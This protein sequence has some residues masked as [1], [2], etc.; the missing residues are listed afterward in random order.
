MG[1]EGHGQVEGG[2][3]WDHASAGELALD[4]P[5]KSGE[6]GEY[7]HLASFLLAI[8]KNFLMS[9]ICLG[10]RIKPVEHGGRRSRRESQMIRRG[11]VRVCRSWGYIQVDVGRFKVSSL[12]SDFVHPK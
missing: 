8:S 1:D 11:C 2:A 12:S 5:D 4:R 9:V 3:S 7:S 6:W 10:Y